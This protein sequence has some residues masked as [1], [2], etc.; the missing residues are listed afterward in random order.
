[1]ALDKQTEHLLRYLSLCLSVSRQLPLSLEVSAVILVLADRQ[2]MRHTGLLIFICYCQLIRW[3][4]LFFS[5]KQYKVEKQL[6]FKNHQTHTLIHTHAHTCIQIN[7]CSHVM[8]VRLATITEVECKKAVH[9]KGKTGIGDWLGGP[10]LHPRLA[11][12][13]GAVLVADCHWGRG[14]VRGRGFGHT[15][16]VPSLRNERSVR[17]GTGSGGLVTMCTL[18]I[19]RRLQIVLWKETWDN[20]SVDLK[21]IKK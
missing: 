15:N 19:W 12:A 21:K 18:A 20:R 2:L 7:I 16:G 14:R 13:H 6:S 8:R 17:G 5:W 11:V 10:V 3:P 1:M 4:L 9:G